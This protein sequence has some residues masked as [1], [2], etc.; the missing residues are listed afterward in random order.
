MLRTCAIVALAGLTSFGAGAMAQTSSEPVDVIAFGSCARERDAQPIWTEIVAQQPDVFLFIGDNMYADFQEE[1]GKL[2][3]KPVTDVRRIEEAYAALGAQDGY[4][5]ILRTCPVLATWDDHDYGAND[6]GKEYPLKE[7]A[8][9]AFW[10]FYGEP[11]TSPLRNQPG[12]YQ[13][14]VL[15]PAGRRV[16]IILLDTRF[17]RDA[18]D[19]A[20]KDQRT[21]R[22]PYLPTTDTSRTLLGEAQWKW[23]E[24]RL[25]EPAEIRL[26]VSSIQVVADEHG[27]ETWGNFPHERQRLYALID[28]TDAGGVVFLS[29]D[30]HLAEISVDRVPRLDGTR[31][32]YPLWDFTSSGM[33]ERAR[34]VTDPNQY[35]VGPVRR[36]TNF[37]VVNIK[38]QEPIEQTQIELIALGDRGQTLNR[39]TLWLGDLREKR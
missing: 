37:G 9:K 7:A 22:G 19:V 28:S 21:R 14:R 1:D 11:P 6:A 34:V 8:K 2:V 27:F 10:D 26:I 20:P 3:M 13:S 31:P 30:R 24:E 16:Q 23:L 12:V 29:G 33:N 4:R 5:R 38:W 32:P 17:N 15:G 25:R 39:Q 35:R 36:E 18:L